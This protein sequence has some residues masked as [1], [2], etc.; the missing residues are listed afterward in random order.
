MIYLGVSRQLCP[1]WYWWSIRSEVL[2]WDE[3]GNAH[4]I[5]HGPS[6]SL[7]VLSKRAT[8]SRLC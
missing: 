4:R 5:Y 2:G 8:C 1:L 7:R 3:A 6:E